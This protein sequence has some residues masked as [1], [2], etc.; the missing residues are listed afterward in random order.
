MENIGKEVTQRY[1]KHEVVEE[2]AT[3][4]TVLQFFVT[5]YD[6][7][8]KAEVSFF[9]DDSEVVGPARWVQL[10][11]NAEGIDKWDTIKNMTLKEINAKV[12]AILQTWEL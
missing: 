10:N 6:H 12:K 8:V 2:K 9:D 5:P 11:P 7:G 3:R 1:E 4:F